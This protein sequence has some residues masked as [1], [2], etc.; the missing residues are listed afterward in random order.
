MKAYCSK[1]ADSTR[2][3]PQFNTQSI[4]CIYIY[5]ELMALHSQNVYKN[6]V[7]H[8]SFGSESSPRLCHPGVICRSWPSK[9]RRQRCDMC[10]DDR[11]LKRTM[12]H[13]ILKNIALIIIP[14]SSA[15]IT[16]CVYTLLLHFIWFLGSICLLCL[17]MLFL[18]SGSTSTSV[19][20][21]PNV[22]LGGHRYWFG[23]P[24]CLEAMLLQQFY[25]KQTINPQVVG[26]SHIT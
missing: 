7:Q 6:Q 12:P 4:V 24:V 8:M 23:H 11:L 16:I 20:D 26:E 5:H 1:F 17:P 19:Q 13:K 3:S 2:F 9:K 18:K 22:G 10:Y 25:Q 21:L 15:I 14:H